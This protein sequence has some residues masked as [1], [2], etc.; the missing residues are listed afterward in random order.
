MPVT[1]DYHL[2]CKHVV[3][4]TNILIFITYLTEEDE[5][6]IDEGKTITITRGD[7]EFIIH[8]NSVYCYGSVNFNDDA[9]DLDIVEGFDFLNH[10]TEVGVKIPANYNFERHECKSNIGRV[11]WTETWNPAELAQYAYGCIGKP[12]RIVLFKQT[13]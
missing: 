4:K 11:K 5:K 10:T 13:H 8:P 9:E 2:L 7:R 12:D 1:K 3:N 6:Q